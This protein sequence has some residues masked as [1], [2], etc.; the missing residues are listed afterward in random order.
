MTDDRDLTAA[1]IATLTWLGVGA[2]LDVVLVRS[3]Q[4]PMTHVLRLGPLVAF[5]T[6]L[7]LHTYD[8]LGRV[9]P[10]RLAGRFVRR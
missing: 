10:F 9:D 3:K 1:W 4:R 6:V 8:V 7:L 5:Q 2:A